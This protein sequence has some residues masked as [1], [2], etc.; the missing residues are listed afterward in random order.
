[1]KRPPGQEPLEFQRRVRHEPTEPEKRFWKALR[2]RH[3]ADAKFRKQVWLGRYLVDF[4]CADAG[5]VVRWMAIRTRIS[6]TT[7]SGGRAGLRM[8]GFV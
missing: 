5:L 6:R 7:M 3:V 2:N 1:M 8:K 4:Y